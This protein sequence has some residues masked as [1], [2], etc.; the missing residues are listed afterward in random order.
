MVRVRVRFRVRAWLDKPWER[1]DFP[2]KVPTAKNQ[3][4]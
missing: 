1:I 2:A 3:E 4:P